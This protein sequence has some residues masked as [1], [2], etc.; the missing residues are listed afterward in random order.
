VNKCELCGSTKNLTMHHLFSQ[1]KINKKL[2]GNLLH[3]KTNILI[4]CLDCHIT[5]P[6]PKQSEL[7]FCEKLGIEPK[8]KEGKLIRERKNDKTQ[9]E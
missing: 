1:T 2:Y 7:E 5:K 9:P 6:I 3:D 4:L 8:S